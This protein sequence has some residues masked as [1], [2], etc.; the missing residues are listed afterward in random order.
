MEQMPSNA[1]AHRQA[2]AFLVVRSSSMWQSLFKPGL[3]GKHLT[4]F[5]A[6]WIIDLNCQGRI[7]AQKARAIKYALD[8]RARPA[9]ASTPTDKEEKSLKTV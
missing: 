2:S 7:N 5:Y 8:G 9:Y 3:M 1:M 6:A 4:L